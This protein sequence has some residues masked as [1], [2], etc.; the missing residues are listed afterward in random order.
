MT[1][2][3]PPPDDFAK[4]TLVTTEVAPAL[5]LRLA[6]ARHLSGDPFRRSA[7]Y[8]F[9]AP[10]ESFGVFYAAVDLETAFVESIVR[11]RAHPLPAGEPLLI[12]YLTL[13]SRHVVTLAASSPARS[14]HLA[15]LYGAGLSAARTDNRIATVDDYG[16]TQRWAKAFHAHPEKIDGIVYMSRYLGNRRSVVL[17]DR[18]RDAIAFNNQD[19]PTMGE[20][21]PRASRENRWHRLYVA[22][23]GESSLGRFVRSRPRRHSIQQSGPPNDGRK[24]STRIQ[25]KSMASS[26]C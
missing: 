4:L 18:A 5:L 10:D 6:S 23:L 21:V 26:I 17:F 22:V 3:D 9:D 25:R 8:R 12:D 7:L 1:A 13:A 14:L 19:H 24:R 11:A 2:L 20:S 16:T 15:Q